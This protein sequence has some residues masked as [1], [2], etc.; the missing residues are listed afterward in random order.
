MDQFLY[1]KII[2]YLKLISF[3]KDM[4]LKSYVQAPTKY[5]KDS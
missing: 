4:K 1:F 2:E 3:L 5:S